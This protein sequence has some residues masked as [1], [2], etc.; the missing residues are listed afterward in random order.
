MSTK[1]KNISI[2]G[3]TGSIGT[4][5]LEVINSHPDQLR[6]VAMAAGGAHKELMLEQ[7]IKYQP[8]LIAVDDVQAAQWL[9][10]QLR[11]HYAS[12]HSAQKPKMTVLD[13]KKVKEQ[14]GV[15]LET[16]VKMIGE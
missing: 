6:L 1:I 11:E 14:F 8:S 12:A 4:Q 3:S 15:D 9:R 16:E 5:S 13:G 10:D 7:A 2:L